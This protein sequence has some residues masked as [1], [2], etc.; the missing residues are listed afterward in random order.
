ML[1]IFGFLT[2]SL[3]TQVQLNNE[4]SL[5][6]SKRRDPVPAA[7]RSVGG[8][9][10]VV[11]LCSGCFAVPVSHHHLL[12]SKLERGPRDSENSGQ[13]L[14]AARVLARGRAL[15]SL[16]HTRSWPRSAHSGLIPFQGVQACWR[17]RLALRGMAVSTQLCGPEEVYLQMK[18][19][20]W[21]C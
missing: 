14:G 19:E 1:Y 5:A 20:Q 7:A 21:N 4:G 6:K 16:P 2:G 11:L 13:S 8:H 17:T 3:I 9:Q 15:A 12:V 18:P 10:F